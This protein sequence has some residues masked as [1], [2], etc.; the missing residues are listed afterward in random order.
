MAQVDLSYTRMGPRIKGPV[1]EA[2]MKHDNMRQLNEITEMIPMGEFFFSP[3]KAQSA[4]KNTARRPVSRLS[5]LNP[6]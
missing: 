3:P 6:T 4:L 2:S 5:M 1:P